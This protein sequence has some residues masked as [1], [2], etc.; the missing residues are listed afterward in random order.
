M[1]YCLLLLLFGFFASN[2]LKCS[3][4]HFGGLEAKYA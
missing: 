3:S 1:N 4:L 2:L